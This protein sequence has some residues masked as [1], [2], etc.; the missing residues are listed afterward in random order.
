MSVATGFPAIRSSGQPPSKP[1]PEKVGSMATPA[2]IPYLRLAVCSV[3]VVVVFLV[4]ALF[5]QVS[6]AGFV[7]ALAAAIIPPCVFV[8][9]WNDGP[10]TTV[11]E[12]L[13]STE[14][15]R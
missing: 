7:F 13:R 11:A 12:L 10:P 6:Q 5:G 14:E 9:L 2:P 3:W 1:S 15:R 4:V 8:A